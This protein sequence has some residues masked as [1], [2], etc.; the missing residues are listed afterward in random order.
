MKQRSWTQWLTSFSDNRNSKSGTADQTRPRRQNWVGIV[1]LVLMLSICEAIAQAQQPGKIFRIG[2]L[3]ASSASGNAGF[4]E[5][6]RQEMSRLG[7][8]EGKSFTIEYRYAEQ[9]RER[10]PDLAAALVRLK[11]DLILVTAGAAVLAAEE[12]TNT[13]PIVMT[14]PAGAVGGG[15]GSR[16][17]RPGSNVNGLSGFVS[18]VYTPRH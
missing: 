8:I 15:N 2:F 1:V 11:V 13:I 6:F 9:K 3:T 16:L 18:E 7:W 17:A 4:L 14:H 5:A 10:L 12:T